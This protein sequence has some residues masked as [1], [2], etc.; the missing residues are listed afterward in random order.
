MSTPGK[1]GT[2]TA[3]VSGVRQA[4]EVLARECEPVFMK[5]VTSKRNWNCFTISEILPVARM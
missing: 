3:P 4:C 1:R 2:G 5:E